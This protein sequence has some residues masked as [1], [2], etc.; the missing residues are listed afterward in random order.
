LEV[1]IDGFRPTAG[2]IA[3][4]ERNTLP[5]KP[6]AAVKQF[7]GFGDREQSFAVSH[8]ER[9]GERNWNILP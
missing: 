3:F 9:L 6:T 2:L 7:S 4:G 5:H 1:H 8:V